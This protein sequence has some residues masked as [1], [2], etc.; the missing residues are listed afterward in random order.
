MI[1]NAAG[2]EGRRFQMVENA[3]NIGVQTRLDGLGNE[4]LAVFGAEDQMH[5]DFGERL[6]HRSFALSGRGMLSWPSSQG[7]ALSFVR[8]CASE[9]NHQ[10]QLAAG[11]SR[12]ALPKSGACWK[13][14]AIAQCQADWS[15]DPLAPVLCMWCGRNWTR[16]SD[17]AVPRS[18]AGFATD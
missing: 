14:A 2:L 5:Q 11:H 13:T 15:D 7:V 12:R 10:I 16:G 1:G 6:G 9:K 18:P 17:A 8:I 3:D 4:R